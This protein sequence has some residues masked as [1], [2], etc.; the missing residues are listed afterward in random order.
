MI[1][2]FLC[3]PHPPTETLWSLPFTQQHSFTNIHWAR[4]LLGSGDKMV[5]K[6]KQDV[7]P[8]G[9]GGLAWETNKYSNILPDKSII[10]NAMKEEYIMPF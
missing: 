4:A 1:L 8:L 9:T 10:I 3:T 6:T 5:A 7:C 2:S